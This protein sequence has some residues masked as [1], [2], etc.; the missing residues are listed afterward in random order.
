[1][2]PHLQYKVPPPGRFK[3]Q[4]IFFSLGVDADY[5]FEN[6]PGITAK[7]N[8]PMRGGGGRNSVRIFKKKKKKKSRKNCEQSFRA[9]NPQTSPTP[10]V[11]EKARIRLD[12][13]K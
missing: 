5:D 13:R 2:S 7:S 10:Q 4:N 11:F 8:S 3:F 9:F 6:V 12:K 1:M